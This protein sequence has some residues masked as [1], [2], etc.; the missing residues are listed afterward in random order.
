MKQSD[1]ARSVGLDGSTI[2]R[3]ESPELIPSL[4]DAQAVLRAIGTEE[5]R[6]YADY[7]GQ[8]W[9]W[10]PRPA[11]EHPERAVLW[12]VERALQRLAELRESVANEGAR[13]QADLFESALRREAAYL[14]IG[15]LR[16]APGKASN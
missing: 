6:A 16:P 14:L 4:A 8:Q 2:S 12:S 5:A 7:L 1:L 10:L 15:S 9:R 13:V 3:Y 11:H